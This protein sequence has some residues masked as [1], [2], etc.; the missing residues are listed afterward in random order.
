MCIRDR[1]WTDKV[2][3]TNKSAQ[4]LGENGLWNRFVNAEYF[5]GHK[6]SD[7]KKWG[8]LE[9]ADLRFGLMMNYYRQNFETKG[10]AADNK[11]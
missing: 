2:N 10:K 5:K 11:L 3:K 7:S 6:L 8:D 9:S 4:Y 1:R